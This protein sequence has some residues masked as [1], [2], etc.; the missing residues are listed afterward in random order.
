VHVFLV[1]HERPLARGDVGAQVALVHGGVAVAL[2]M[3]MGE[4]EE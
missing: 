2:Q 4:E 3:L 1:D